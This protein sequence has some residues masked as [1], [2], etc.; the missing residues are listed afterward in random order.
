MPLWGTFAVTEGTFAVTGD[1]CRYRGTFAVT[2]GRLPLWGD[3]C[4]Y[5]DRTS[6]ETSKRNCC[7]KY[8]M[9]LPLSRATIS[10]L[11]HMVVFLDSISIRGQGIREGRLRRSIG[12]VCGIL[13]M[14]GCCLSLV[15]VGDVVFLVLPS[16]IRVLATAYLCASM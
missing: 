1:V 5:E 3:V 15:Q 13:G 12:S 14:L 7:E 16:L 10:P 8:E 11:D 4:R 2:G 6:L 9:E